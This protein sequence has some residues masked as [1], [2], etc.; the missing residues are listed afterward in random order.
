MKDSYHKQYLIGKDIDRYKI[1][2]LKE[3]FI[4]YGAWLA[5]PRNIVAFESKKIILRQTSDIIRATIDNYMFY[6]LNNIY[7]IEVHNISYSYEYLLGI[8]NSKFMIYIYQSLVP[9]KGKLFA[10]IKKSNL[11]KI[12]IPRLK[13]ENKTDKKTTT[14][15]SRWSNK[16]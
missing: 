16:C 5:E 9:E 3:R 8:L 6:N 12:P 11:D 10:E 15:W 2:P 7:N 1:L 13:L 14:K 4:K